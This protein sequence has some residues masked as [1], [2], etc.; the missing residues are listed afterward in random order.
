MSQSVSRS[1]AHLIPTNDKQAKLDDLLGSF[2]DPS[3]FGTPVKLDSSNDNGS[4]VV[5]SLP[6]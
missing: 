6:C 4:S 3:I 2:P 1:V 5:S